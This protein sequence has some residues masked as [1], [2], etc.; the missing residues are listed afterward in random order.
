MTLEQ[1]ILKAIEDDFGRRG[2]NGKPYKNHSL[3]EDVTFR[4]TDLAHSI[5]NAIHANLATLGE[6]LDRIKADRER[7]KARDE[8]TVTID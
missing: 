1:I 5:A 4:S 6:L 3:Y 8:I 7:E 2:W